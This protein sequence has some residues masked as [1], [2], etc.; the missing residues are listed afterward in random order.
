MNPRVIEITNLTALSD[1]QALALRTLLDAAEQEDLLRDN[2]DLLKNYPVPAEQQIDIKI[3]DSISQIKIKLTNKTLTLLQYENFLRECMHKCI[4]AFTA[5]SN[6]L[7]AKGL[8][9]S[10]GKDVN[11]V[12]KEWLVIKTAIDKAILSDEMLFQAHKKIRNL[13]AQI[14]KVTARINDYPVLTDSNNISYAVIGV[15]KSYPIQ[16]TVNNKSEGC[17]LKVPNSLLYRR[18]KHRDEGI[19]E[20]VENK[21]NGNAGEVGVLS[22]ILGKIKKFGNKIWFKEYGVATVSQYLDKS[23]EITKETQSDYEQEVAIAKQLPHAHIKTTKLVGKKRNGHLILYKHE[24]RDLD[25]AIYDDEGKTALKIFSR[26]VDGRDLNVYR[27]YHGQLFSMMYQLALAYQRQIAANN[28]VHGDLTAANVMING[29]SFEELGF[30][31]FNLIDFSTTQQIGF[32]KP[33]KRGVWAYKPPEFFNNLA[34]S[35]AYDIYPLGVIFA[36]LIVAMFGERNEFLA[37]MPKS[38]NKMTMD[39]LTNYKQNILNLCARNLKRGKLQH[40]SMLTLIEE[41]LAEEGKRPTI[42]DVVARLHKFLVK[43]PFGPVDAK[44]LAFVEAEVP[45]PLA[46]Q[47]SNETFTARINYATKGW[48][49]FLDVQADKIT[50]SLN[51]LPKSQINPVSTYLR[52]LNIKALSVCATTDAIANVFGS[53]K[54]N[55]LSNQER[56]QNCH[57]KLHRL[58][59]ILGPD[60]CR[61]NSAVIASLFQEINGTLI[62]YYKMPMT[63]DNCV[64]L[65][66]KVALRIPFIEQNI[67]EFELLFLQRMKQQFAAEIAAYKTNCKNSWNV[68]WNRRA[69]SPEKHKQIVALE[70]KFNAAEQIADLG[71]L[72]ADVKKLRRGL[73]GKSEL[74]T[75]M[76]GIAKTIKKYSKP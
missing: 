76:K 36:E 63:V 12:I 58:V 13:N 73:F 22:N 34:P 29:K 55:L 37:I 3:E 27:A 68:F 54:Q 70:N 72:S 64:L 31:E 11:L 24:D 74:R 52:Y 42:A 26:G 16:I 5:F 40:S 17:L 1:E 32:T 25:N 47:D 60:F 6:S 51:S 43:L 4:S 18:S 59:Q 14:V 62:K 75:R 39:I 66:E 33:I 65:N 21:V 49:D 10:L 28:L 9:G 19:Y 53:T 67:V 50:K 23:I 35:N 2:L 57:K 48:G 69:Y 15:G 45:K 38:E 8:Y 41:M 56:L 30:V 7:L 61:D 71:N 46:P 44:E 20:V